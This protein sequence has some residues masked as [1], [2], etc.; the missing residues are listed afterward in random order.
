MSPYGL[1]DP[2]PMS[3]ITPIGTAGTLGAST[4]VCATRAAAAEAKREPFGALADGTPIE[5]V[6]LSNNSGMTVRVITLG[7]SIQSLRVPDRYGG[8]GDIVLGFS[9]AQ[10]YMDDSN[11]FGATIGRFANRIAKG[12]FSLDGIDY[13]LATNDHGN[14]LHGGKRGFD[15]VVWTLDSA[16]GGSAATA[17]F[18]YVSADGEEGYAGTLHVTA[19]YSL[20]DR[21][22]LHIEYRATTDKTTIVNITGHSYFNLAGAD[23]HGSAMAHLVQIHA[24]RYTPVDALLIPTGEL[25]SVDGTPF[26]FRAPTPVGQR[27]RDGRDPQIRRG[28]GYDHNFLIDGAAGELRIAARVEDPQSGRVLEIL[29]TAP[30]LQFYSGNFLAATTAGKRARLY[31]QGDGLAFEP[32]VFP[33]APNH[34]SF[35]SARLD[36]DHVFRNSIEYRFSV[37]AAPEEP[38]ASAPAR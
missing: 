17:V 2:P 10:E 35:P 3:A 18:S 31:R 25:R 28:R 16:T 9:T 33:D 11:Y 6:N 29:T 8:V 32:Q 13:S 5:A 22:V 1:F 19:T 37:A 20:D 36:P 30:G 15:K 24:S 38:P 14:H 34:S 23:R 21:N 4:G 27:I 26:D 7:A 12:R